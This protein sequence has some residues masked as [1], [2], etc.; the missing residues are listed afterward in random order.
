MEGCLGSVVK[1]LLFTTNFLVLV[2]SCAVF[3]VSIWFLVD[4]PSFMDLFSKAEEILDTDA[5]VGVSTAAAILLLVISIFVII[6]AFFGCCG[7]YKENRCMLG[8]YFAIVLA[9]F[10]VM[11]VGAVLGYTTDFDKAIKNP[12][13]DSLGKYKDTGDLTD[14][15]EA[16]KAA[17]NQAQKDFKCCGIT[18][19]GDWKLYAP[20]ADFPTTP[21]N[22]NK[23]AGCC[24]VY[25]DGTE[26]ATTDAQNSCRA[27]TNTT[28]PPPAGKKYNFNG[29][30][31]VFKDEIK[32]NQSIVVGVAIGIVVVMFLNMLFAFAMCTMSG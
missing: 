7:A 27:A 17:W 1:A 31:T 6:V 2:L 14:V 23:P 30:Y 29:C 4:S 15:Q 20:D 5:A 22:M 3:G 13:Q 10:V 32:D 8:T 24:M 16:Y 18:D 28:N 11:I 12:L 25:N 21:T 26:I 19:Y 9:A